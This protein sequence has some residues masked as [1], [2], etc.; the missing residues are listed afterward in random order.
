MNKS[1]LPDL[2]DLP[3]MAMPASL[4]DKTINTKMT[5]LKTVIET[6]LAQL[7]DLATLELLLPVHT[8]MM[9]RLESIRKSAAAEH[10]K[11][12]GHWK[13][14]APE[15]HISN[16]Q[17]RKLSNNEA[18]ISFEVYATDKDGNKQLRENKATIEL[19]DGSKIQ[20]VMSAEYV[21]GYEVKE[22]IRDG[23]PIERE[24]M[25]LARAED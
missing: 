20:R 3:D 6:K 24:V 7:K 25:R 23:K 9:K 22:I 16:L 5:D 11:I 12:R 4:H 19:H 17:G 1:G 2:P 15:M 14:S 13:T 8:R 21:K 18:E 10:V